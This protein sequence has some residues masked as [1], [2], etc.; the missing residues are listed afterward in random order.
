M[1]LESEVLQSYNKIDEQYVE[2]LLEKE[3]KK[4]NKTFVVLDDDPTGVQTVHDVSVYTDWEEESI[5]NGF[6]EKEA[7][8]FYPYQFTKLFCGENY[9]SS[10]GYCRKSGEGCQRAGTGLHGSFPWRFHTER[11]LSAGNTASGRWPDKER[12]AL[13]LTGRLSVRFSQKAGAIQWIISIT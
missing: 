1:K 3:I 10:S 2:S 12:G 4:N 5:R 7:M 13:L 8:F 9:K 6:E 11:L